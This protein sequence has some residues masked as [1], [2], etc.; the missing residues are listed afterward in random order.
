M[1]FLPHE[2]VEVAGIWCA[3]Q[4]FILFSLPLHL[5]QYDFTVCV[6]VP[7]EGSTNVTEWFTV[8]C[9]D[10]FGSNPIYMSVCSPFIC[11]NESAR[12]YMALIMGS[13]VAS[14]IS[15]LHYFH[16]SKSRNM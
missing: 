9:E 12:S 6:R 15:L 7:V 4:P 2:F 1:S 13:N 14:S 8:E 11:M 3:S 10:T 16:V 5:F